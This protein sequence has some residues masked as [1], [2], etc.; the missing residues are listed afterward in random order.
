M[1]WLPFL[2][3]REQLLGVSG[4][5]IMGARSNVPPIIDWPRKAARGSTIFPYR[6]SR[7]EKQVFPRQ[8]RSRRTI[9][10]GPWSKGLEKIVT[11]KEAHSTKEFQGK[12]AGVGNSCFFSIISLY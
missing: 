6:S 7:V 12:A 10:V 11:Y 4:P 3:I 2:A 8:C 9:P 1:R 5:Y